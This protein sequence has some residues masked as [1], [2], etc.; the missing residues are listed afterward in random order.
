[1][2][3]RHRKFEERTFLTRRDVRSMPSL[4]VSEVPLQVGSRLGPCWLVLT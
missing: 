1:M 2:L 3:F 4:E